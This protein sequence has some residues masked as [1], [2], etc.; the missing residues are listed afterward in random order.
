MTEGLLGHQT[1][2]FQRIFR[3]EDCR[4]DGSFGLVEIA[5]RNNG[6]SDA[7]RPHAGG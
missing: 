6:P 5:V 3:L 4:G 1:V 2:D 7:S